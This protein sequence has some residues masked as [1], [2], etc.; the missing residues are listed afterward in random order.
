MILSQ[1]L[2]GALSRLQVVTVRHRS[3]PPPPPRVMFSS[4]KQTG[5]DPALVYTLCTRVNLP[6]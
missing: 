5:F 4:V 2:A 3:P 1:L 6:V